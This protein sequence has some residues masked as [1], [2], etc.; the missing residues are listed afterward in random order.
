MKHSVAVV[1]PGQDQTTGQGLCQYRSAEDRVQSGSADVQSPQRIEAVVPPSPNPGSR[2]RT[3]PAIGHYDVVS[4]CVDEDFLCLPVTSALLAPAVWNSI[5]KT[6]VNSD[7][8]AVFKSRLELALKQR[9]VRTSGNKVRNK[10][11]MPVIAASPHRSPNT[12]GQSCPWV[13]LTHGLGWV[14]LGPLQQKC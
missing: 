5:P 6:V 1:D 14:G 12:V 8:V 10:T 11:R 9:S 3:Q 4:T 7:S 13:G 2:T